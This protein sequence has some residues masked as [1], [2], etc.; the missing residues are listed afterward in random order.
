MSKEIKNILILDD[1]PYWYERFRLYT[2][3]TFVI[4]SKPYFDEKLLNNGA[5]YDLLM[6]DL[7]FGMLGREGF[8]RGLEEHLPKAANLL[9]GK[10]PIIVCTGDTRRDTPRIAMEKG[11][12]MVFLKSEYDLK[13]WKTQILQVIDDFQSNGVNGH[14]TS[15][16][17]EVTDGFISVSP[18]ISAIKRRLR[19]LATYT[20]KSVLLQGETGVGKEVAARYIHQ[21]KDN[22][23]LP[24]VPVHL[25]G[26]TE[27]IIEAELFGHVK[28]AFSGA[29]SDRKGLFEAAGM[30]T[31]FLDE[32]GEINE[33]LQ[34]KL[35]RVLQER[36]FR[37]VGDNKL[38][39]L[40]AQIVFATNVNLP[41]AVEARLFRLDLF[42]RINQMP[43][44][45]PPLRERLDDIE[46]LLDYFLTQEKGSPFFGQKCRDCFSEKALDILKL[47]DW[48]GNVRELKHLLG[49][50]LFEADM[51]EKKIIDM[52]LLPDR[53]RQPILINPLQR[54]ESGTVE[55]KP[56]NDLVNWS[57]EKHTAYTELV[58][59]EK[60]LIDSS[61]RKDDAAKSLGLKNDQSI[62]YKV[63]KKYYAK[64]PELFSYFPTIRRIYKLAQTEPDQEDEP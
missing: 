18:E 22:P 26:K 1:K 24:F 40:K 20:N 47:Y 12:K 58:E 50:V 11:A 27:S 17:E 62:R 8:Q 7:D 23:D 61:G 10:T 45:I 49:Q 43:I 44:H 36:E 54:N 21:A 34:A 25:A 57:M 33:E 48:P 16:H 29:I 14:Q 37:R 38:I 15:A 56:N 2:K 5:T 63:K 4:E 28:G 35:L 6:L 31:L 19:K 42:Q 53:F 41:E 39:K 30:G 32:I 46:P 64:Y 60:A 3:G 55:A 52:D 13:K 9:N 59:I 51:E